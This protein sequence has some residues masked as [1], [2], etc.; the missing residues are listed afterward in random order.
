MKAM[1]SIIIPVYNAET[2]MSECIDSIM[3]QSYSNLELILVDDGSTDTSGEICDLYSK[4]Y[5]NIMSLHRKNSGPGA[6]RNAGIAEAKGDYIGFVDA[7]DYIEKSMYEKL[8]AWAEINCAEVAICDYF[9]D[10]EGTKKKKIVTYD[11]PDNISLETSAIKEY[12]VPQML[13]SGVNGGLCNKIFRRDFFEDLK[14]KGIEIYEAIDYGEDHFFL[15]EMFIHTKRITYVKEPLYHY[16]HRKNGSLTKKKRKSSEKLKIAYN[17]YSHRL[18]F[19]ENFEVSTEEM[20]KAYFYKLSRIY[21]DN[22][23]DIN[24]NLF[25]KYYFYDLQNKYNM[26]DLKPKAFIISFLIKKKR[27][28]FLKIL[29][30]IFAFKGEVEL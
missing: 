29:P 1:I 12:I 9:I 15:M 10:Y 8:V 25:R 16:V 4:K 7:D 20:E 11:M 24:E 6:A 26:K 17:F 2:Y 22:I 14:H 19:A 18:S 27:Y 13:S 5:K 30:Y 28:L 23:D 21:L 3:Q